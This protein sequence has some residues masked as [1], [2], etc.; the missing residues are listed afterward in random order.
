MRSFNFNR[1]KNFK[2]KGDT[3]HDIKFRAKAYGMLYNTWVEGEC[4]VIHESMTHLIDESKVFRQTIQRYTGFNDENGIDIYEGDIIRVYYEFSYDED[5]SITYGDKFY[6]YVIIYKDNLFYANNNILIK[7]NLLCNTFFNNE[8]EKIFVIGNV[9]DNREHELSIEYNTNNLYSNFMKNYQLYYPELIELKFLNFAYKLYKVPMHDYGCFYSFE[10]NELGI[11]FDL[12]NE[13]YFI[14]ETLNE[15][16]P[17]YTIF[18]PS[19]EKTI[20]SDNLEE[21]L[22]NIN[23]YE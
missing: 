12:N 14:F 5:G 23:G 8:N 22:L 4:K 13:N 10:D 6:D 20:E 1:V 15:G 19:N 16:V 2:L 3:S 9:L 17:K 18:I 21:L 11:M 7:E